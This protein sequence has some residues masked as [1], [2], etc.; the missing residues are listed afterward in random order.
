MNEY[1]QRRLSE[2]D[3]M[4][5]DFGFEVICPRGFQESGDPWYD[6]WTAFGNIRN[7]LVYPS[8]IRIRN[9]RFKF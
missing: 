2:L 1:L 6:Y 4:M 7:I 5:Y 9:P 8:A 3:G